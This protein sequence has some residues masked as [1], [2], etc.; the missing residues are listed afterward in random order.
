MVSARDTAG[1]RT[2]IFDFD[3]TLAN[4]L[5]LVFRLYNEH[6]LSFGARQIGIKEIDTYRKLGYKKAMKKAG[7][8]WTTLPRIMLFISR[9]MKKHMHEVSPYEGVITQIQSLQKEG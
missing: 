8:R 5:E 2:V 3:G 9:E 7:V 4:T 6:A 1:E